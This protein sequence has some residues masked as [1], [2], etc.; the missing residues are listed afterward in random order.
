M[1]EMAVVKRFFIIFIVI[2]VIASCAAC[3]KAYGLLSPGHPEINQNMKDY[4]AAEAIATAQGE[5]FEAKLL[6]CIKIKAA[7]ATLYHYR[8]VIA[9]RT[10][11]PLRKLNAWF[12]PPPA[13][14][15][16]FVKDYSHTHQPYHNLLMKGFPKNR[17]SNFEPFEPM[18]S[19]GALWPIEYEFTW[20]N[21]DNEIQ[22][23]EGIA[24]EAFDDA[25]RTLSFEVHFNGRIEVLS[26]SIDLPFIEVASAEE[27]DGL[28][29]SPIAYN[30]G[31]LKNILA[32]G[33]GGAGR[34]PYRAPETR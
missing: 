11:R 23:E 33:V 25:M 30:K 6:Q 24:D 18:R 3:A 10:E 5:F 31:Y 2:V 26:L 15:Q 32:D 21:Y 16:Y 12:L 9:P 27:I 14:S 17:S 13:L 29:D 19:V 20:S 8:V 7:N 4:Y 22:V 28:D 1:G 34:K